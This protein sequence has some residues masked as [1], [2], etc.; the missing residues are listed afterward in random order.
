MKKRKNISIY[1]LLKVCVFLVFANS[2]DKVKPTPVASFTMDKSDALSGELI[3]FLNNSKYASKYS[4]DFGDGNTSTKE[5]PTHSYSENGYFNIILTAIGD[6]GENSVS[7]TI[8]IS[9][10][11][12]FTDERDGNTYKIVKIGN[13]VWMAENLNYDI[14]GSWVY[15]NISSNANIYGRLY[16]WETACSVCPSGWHLPSDEEWKILEMAIGMSQIDANDSSYRGFNEGAKL[17][18]T[19]GWF[20]HGGG[21][22]EYGF[23]AIPGGINRAGNYYFW[24]S[25]AFFWSKTQYGNNSAWFRTL[26]CDK[27]EIYRNHDKDYHGYSVRCLKN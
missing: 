10:F 24:G 27:E 13:Q 7:E 26:G 20:N 5:N 19:S 11:S 4:W 14:V 6:G 23:T 3:T 21:T 25:N 1:L 16:N 12:Q 17:K 18:A 22:D 15:N 8:V 9:P 2:C